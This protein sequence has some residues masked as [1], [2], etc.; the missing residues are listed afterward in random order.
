MKK[1]WFIALLAVVFMACEGPEG[2]EGPPGAGIVREVIDL[3]VDS[4]HW[5][6]EDYGDNPY[7]TYTFK[8][9]KIS[10]YVYDYATITVH[11]YAQ[12][13]DIDSGYYPLPDIFPYE[14]GFEGPA[15]T[16]Y[17]TYK[18]DIGQITFIAQYSNFMELA[19]LSRSFRV[20]LE[21]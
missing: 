9:S 4:S 5:Q 6:L 3:H 7:Y 14:E 11:V 20:V 13:K 1:I 18:I 8:E 10:E 19:P 15:W 16:E 12:Y 21:W 17:Y 2:P